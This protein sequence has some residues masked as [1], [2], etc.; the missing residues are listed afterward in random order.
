MQSPN[1]PKISLGY[2]YTTIHA[3]GCP[4]SY[5][6]DTIFDKFECM[7]QFILNIVAYTIIF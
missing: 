2:T 1:Y 5:P 3:M 6:L 4:I 7:F